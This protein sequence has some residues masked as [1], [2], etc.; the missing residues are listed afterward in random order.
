MGIGVS[1]GRETALKAAGLPIPAVIRVSALLDTG[2]SCTCVDP[3]VLAP[4]GLSTTGPAHI[5][6]PSTGA[7]PAV[8]DQFD[9]SLMIAGTMAQP[10]LHLKTVPIV[11]SPL[12][13]QGFDAL[14]G[15]DVLKQCVLHYNDTPAKSSLDHMADL[16]RKILV[17]K[18]SE[19]PKPKAKKRKR[20]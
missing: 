19:L 1:E 9:V 7:A 2:A 6:T 3:S 8:F 18:K 10:I 11:A 12:K 16:T 4:L 20:R 14:L 13:H 5:I 17:V 15:R